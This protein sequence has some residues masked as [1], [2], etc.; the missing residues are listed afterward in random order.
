MWDWIKRYLKK[1]YKPTLP[2]GLTPED[3]AIL[4]GTDP[5]EKKKTRPES[6]S[7]PSPD[8]AR[9]IRGFA[10]DGIHFKYTVNDRQLAKWWKKLKLKLKGTEDA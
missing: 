1:H 8:A 3:F 6:W 7:L 4:S 5:P 10:G 9:S 2:E